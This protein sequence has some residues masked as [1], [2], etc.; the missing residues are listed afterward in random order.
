[1]STEQSSVKRGPSDDRVWIQ[2]MMTARD[3]MMPRAVMEVQG[4]MLHVKLNRDIRNYAAAA[5]RAGGTDEWNDKPEI[6]S[7]SEVLGV[8]ESSEADD[9]V[10][11]VPNQIQGQW[12]GTGAYLKA[13]YD[14]LREDTIAPLRD[15][16]AYYRECIWMDDTSTVSVYEKV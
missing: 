10:E 3:T 8:N 7:T 9:I 11:L 4:P 15:A 1:M 2:D 16:V 6:P 13:H 5:N 12:P 14:L